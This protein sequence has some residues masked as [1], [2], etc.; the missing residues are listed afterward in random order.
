M[1]NWKSSRILAE[2]WDVSDGGL[3]YTF[4]LR[5]DIEFHDGRAVTADDLKWSM[6]RATDPATEA[7]TVSVFLGDIAGVRDKLEG[8]AFNIAGV[9]VIDQKTISITADAPK[10]YLLAKLS[11][12]TSFVLDRNNLEGNDDWFKQPN[13]TGPF[14]LDEYIPGELIRLTANKN[15]HLGAPHVDEVMHILSGGDALLMYEND[16]IHI[17]GVGIT[18]LDAILD[19]ANPL[20]TDVQRSP[21]SF[22]TYFMG[23]NAK[24]P[25]FDDKN[26]RLALN[27]AIDRDTIS[28]VLPP[29]A[30]S[31]CQWGPPSGVPRIRPQPG[32][33]RVRS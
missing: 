21:P 24:E 27:Y 30:V 31:A 11:Y 8:N 7:P 15:Y 32:R 25:P 9:K 26:V 29:G 23:L 20:S 6:E 5:D 3:T 33:L 12:P 28:E 1:G 2:R 19:P 18:S 4:S 13:G 22:S 17:T 10:A 14:L 16:E